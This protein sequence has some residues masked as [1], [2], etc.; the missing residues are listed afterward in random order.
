[1]VLIGPGGALSIMSN[2]RWA[3]LPAISVSASWIATAVPASPSW[4]NDM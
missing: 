2:T 1:L 4:S 3:S